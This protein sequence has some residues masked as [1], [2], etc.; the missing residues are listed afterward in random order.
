MAAT[1]SR[2]ETHTMTVNVLP[3]RRAFLQASG[4]ITGAALVA[5]ALPRSGKRLAAHVSSHHVGDRVS[6]D[7]LRYGTV[8]AVAAENVSVRVDDSATPQEWHRTRAI[9]QG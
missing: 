3:S 8:V 2:D 7:G 4:V 1:R 9:V 5:A 6:L